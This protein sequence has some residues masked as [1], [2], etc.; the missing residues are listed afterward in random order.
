MTKYY[1]E[2]VIRDIATRIDIIDIVAETVELKR[3]G[4]RYWGLCP[5][6]PEK[7]ASFSVSQDRQMFYCFGCHAGG[8]I[9]SF[10]MRREGLEFKEA[11][12]L[13]A[14]KA[15]VQLAGSFEKKNI[16]NRKKVI[17]VNQ[18]A[19]EFYQKLLT[20][21]QG[22]MAS[23]Y[24]NNRGITAESVNTFKLGYAPDNWNSLQDYL[25]NKGFPIENVK[26]SGVIKRSEK[27]NNYYDIFR[28]RIIY[29]IVNYSG[30]I[31]GFGGRVLDDSLPKY[32]NSPETE[33]F[34][35]RNNLY[36]L[37]HA[38][39]SIRHENEAILVEG[40]MDCIK[41][42]QAGIK[43]VVAS[44]G[45]SFTE[46]QARL[47]RRYAEKILILYDGDEAGQRETLRAI[48]I[49]TKTG[50]KVDVLTLPAGKDP[51]EY[52]Q[53]FGKE[54]FWQY[55]KN[56]RCSYIEFKINRYI[57]SAN[58]VNLDDKTMVIKHMQEDINN[59][60]TEMEKDYYIKMLAQKLRVEEN[61]IYRQYNLNGRKQL[62]YTSTNK[63]QIIR[64]NNKY[65]NYGIQEKIL[66]AL[67]NNEETFSKVKNAIGLDFFKNPQ[68]KEIIRIFDELEGSH[69]DKLIILR[70]TAVDKKL[71]SP[72]ARISILMD[73]KDQLPDEIEIDRFI[74][75]VKM[76][77]SQAH[78]Q[79]V[80]NNVNNLGDRGDFTSMM[81]FILQL[82]RFL[83][84]TQEGGIK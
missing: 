47:L 30:E 20:S 79:K 5:F 4:N 8:N 2:Q 48:D 1:D 51:D 34:S 61:V 12:E 77:K 14:R 73:E 40:Y 26:S 62:Y 36:G 68:Y 70:E 45:T 81:Q 19:A 56:N 52:L 17:E 43:N 27:H 71:E 3:K 46:E 9:F 55:I 72:F 82:D 38:R 7:T 35:K 83:D 78:W 44:L 59:L 41:L 75:K 76:L 60:D 53:V 24:L 16:D 6:H 66:A 11:L 28:N 69:Y 18:A 15:G 84:D 63:T 39:D 32:L 65:G 74:S 54:E 21:E 57:K 64:D 42:H 13:L 25:L 67:L 49:I 58:M 22:R 33:I 23:T 80:L 37:Y 50:I 29:P 31:I 10:I